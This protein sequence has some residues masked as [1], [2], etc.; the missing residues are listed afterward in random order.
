MTAPAA[1][2]ERADPLVSVIVP[3]YNAAK[4]LRESLDSILAQT[5]RNV[6]VIV[7]D[8]ASTDETPAIIASYGATVRSFRQPVNQGTFE[9]TN[10]GISLARGEHIAVYHADDVYD[11]EIVEQEVGFLAAHPDVGAVF[12]LD[13]FVDAANRAYGRLELPGELRGLGVLSYDRVLNGLLRYKNC[14]LTCPGAMVRAAVYRELGTYRQPQFGIAADLEMWVRI[15]RRYPLGLLE[16][17]LFR[18]RHFHGNWTQRY[19]HLRTS[20]E[21]FFTVMDFYLDNGARDLA[22][23]DALDAYEAHRDEDRL[24]LAVSHYVRGDLGAAR[25]VLAE[26]RVARI[27]RGSTAQRG[28]LVILI[29]AFRLLSRLPRVSAF[30]DLFFDRWFVKHAPRPAA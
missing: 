12:C 4:F 5:Y 22:V 7:V 3:A 10:V 11:T 15:A 19:N 28:R 29:V 25:A 20:P 8:D 6:E 26:I 16:E 27:A 18:Y 30:A 24:F 1:A 14:F 17:H 23:D 13:V 21:K 2:P 9:N